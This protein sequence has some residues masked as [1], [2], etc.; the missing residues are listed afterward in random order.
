MNI[1]SIQM[2]YFKPK[3]LRCNLFIKKLHPNTYLVALNTLSNLT[4][5][6]TL[7]PMGG[8]NLAAMS[9]ISIILLHTTK[10]S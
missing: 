3:S 5:R 7:I 8:N 1:P 9:T 2:N 4:Q 10:Q 6:S